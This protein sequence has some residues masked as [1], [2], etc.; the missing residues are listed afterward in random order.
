MMI[1]FDINAFNKYIQFL[2]L[3]INP[4]FEFFIIIFLG[5]LAYSTSSEFRDLTKMSMNFSVVGTVNRE[6]R[7]RELP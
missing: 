3:S 7:E 2:S 1:E 5:V 6:V 4:S